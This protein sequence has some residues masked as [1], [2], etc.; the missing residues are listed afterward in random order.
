MQNDDI[1]LTHNQ[2]QPKNWRNNSTKTPLTPE[3]ELRRRQK[4]AIGI[5]VGVFVLL[6]L[7]AMVGFII[8]SVNSATVTI[9]VAPTDATVTIDGKT[10]SN[11]EYHMQPGTYSVEVSRDGFELYSGTLDATAGEESTVAVCLDTTESTEGWYDDDSTEDYQVC[12]AARDRQIIESEQ[13]WLDSD[14]ILR[15][16]PYRNYNGGYNIDYSTD[17]NKNITVTVTT[18]TCQATRAESL[19]ANALEYLT[20]QG[21][22]ISQYNIVQKSGCE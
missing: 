22:D 2:S 15:I 21:I 18:L 4:M 13:A 10:F 17:E 3:D 11:G 7:V 12:Q 19:Y 14:P 6:V 8:R 16:L 20:D 1:I 5:G 9:A